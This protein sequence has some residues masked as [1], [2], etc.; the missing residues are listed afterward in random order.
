MLDSAVSGARENGAKVETFD[1]YKMKFFGCVSCFSCKRLDRERPIICAV[2][3]DL[4]PVLEQVRGID[5]MLIATPVYFGSETAA[6]RA[7]IERLCFPHLNYAD[8]SNDCQNAR[9][10]GVHVTTGKPF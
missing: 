8:F 10:L 4:K 2:E 6:V 9:Q 5:A 3:D 7:L 1:L